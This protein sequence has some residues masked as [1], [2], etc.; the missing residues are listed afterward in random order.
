[1]HDRNAFK[2]SFPWGA[3]STLAALFGTAAALVTLPTVS[4]GLFGGAVIMQGIG[5]YSNYKAARSFGISEKTSAVQAAAS[6]M[7]GF[8]VITV[9][10][11]V[12]LAALTLGPSAGL[13][14][15]GTLTAKAVSFIKL[16]TE[17]SFATAFIS[18]GW[19]LWKMKKDPSVRPELARIRLEIRSLKG[20]L[21][22]R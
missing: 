6:T 22:K 9:L 8:V 10:A 4:A 17:A 12:S 11:G 2:K 18:N 20:E 19:A 1:M 15:A 7:V 13:I 14:A 21:S 16:V 5:A 3:T